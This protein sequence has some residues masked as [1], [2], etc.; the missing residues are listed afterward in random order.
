M[1]VLKNKTILIMGAPGTGKGSYSKLLSKKYMIPVYSS[2][3]HLRLI[4]KNKD[5]D[6]S[7][8]T[9]IIQKRHKIDNLRHC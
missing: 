5:N 2:G 4:I 6:S 7:K 8:L 1:N 9:E 3:D